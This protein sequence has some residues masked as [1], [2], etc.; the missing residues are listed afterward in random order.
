MGCGVSGVVVR[1]VNVGCGAEGGD[2]GVCTWG[3][4]RAQE[5]GQS[6]GGQA[7]GGLLDQDL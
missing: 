7:L 3:V 4:G 2:E 1:G 5:M 6:K